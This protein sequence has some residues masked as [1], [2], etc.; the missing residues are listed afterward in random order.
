MKSTPCQADAAK[1][2][3]VSSSH[4]ELRHIDGAAS[5]IALEYGGGAWRILVDGKQVGRNADLAS[6]KGLANAKLRPHP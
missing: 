4:H 5:G 2:H 1:W 3:K 6:A